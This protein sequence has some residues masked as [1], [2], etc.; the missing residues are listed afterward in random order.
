VGFVVNNKPFVCKCIRDTVDGLSDGLSHFSGPSRVAVI[1]AI[2]PQD[3]VRIYDPQDL[4]KGHELILKELYLDAPGWRQMS[5]PATGKNAFSNMAPVGDLELAGLISFGGRSG[6][7]FYQMWFTEHH[8]E[9][10]SVGPTRRWLEHAAWRFSHDMAN[11]AELYTAVSGS[12]LKE[13][14]AHAVRD[15]IVDE[16]NVHLGWDTQLRIYPI[17]DAILGISRTAEEG[18][19]ARGN[20]RFVEGR[21]L[22]DLDFLA[23]FPEME[24]PYLAHHKHVRKLLTAVENSDRVLVS[25]GKAIVG[26]AQSSLPRFSI[27]ADF[28]GGHGF[29]Y[30]NSDLICSFADGSFHSKTYQAKLVQVEEVLLETDLDASQDNALFK[31]I[32][33]I[34]HNAEQSKHGC[35]L[36]IDLSDQP[37]QLSGQKLEPS[38]DLQN[39]GGLQL[40][41]SLSKVDGA[42]HIGKDLKLHGFACLLDGQAIAGEDRSRGARYN[43][44]L[45]FTAAHTELLVVVVSSDRPVSVIQEGVELNA[46][47]RWRASADCALM[48]TSLEAWVGAAE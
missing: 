15:L 13:Y 26:I 3:P 24:Q 32:S 1:Y 30:V 39:I 48:P 41:Q 22:N 8:A 12:F 20:L 19:W 38:I 40:A 16:M 46:L 4:L 43:S 27:T 36:V 47:C 31:I 28:R 7:V 14:A 37:L 42:L 5:P 23:R 11:E 44:A 18:A 10:C 34:V 45:R 17:L 35:T 9:M 29:L 25:N 2:D 6:S 33:N 21:T